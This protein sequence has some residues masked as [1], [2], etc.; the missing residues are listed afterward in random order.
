M[1][2]TISKDN[3][4]SVVYIQGAFSQNSNTD[5]AALCFQNYD[6]DTKIIYNMAEISM[7]DSYGTSCNNGVGELLFKTNNSNNLQER[8]RITHDGKVCIGTDHGSSLLNINGDVQIQDKLVLNETFPTIPSQNNVNFFIDST[9]HLLKLVNNSNIVTTLNPLKIKGDIVVYDGNTETRLPKGI[10][11]QLLMV[12]ETSSVGLAWK[13]VGPIGLQN[14]YYAYVENDVSMSTTST[15]YVD[16]IVFTASNL[17]AGKYRV[18]VSYCV[19]IP[20][21]SNSISVF[22]L[23]YGINM[24]SYIDNSSLTWLT[25]NHV[26]KVNETPLYGSFTVKALT[27]GNHN[28]YLQCKSLNGSPVC[29]NNS[30]I[31]LTFVG[32][33]GSDSFYD[34]FEINSPINTNATDYITVL[35]YSATFLT[36]GQYRIGVSYCISL[37]EDPYSVQLF[38][39]VNSASVRSYYDDQNKVWFSSMHYLNYIEDPVFYNFTVVNLETGDHT[40]YIQLKSMSG[41]DII[42]QNSK[43]EITLVV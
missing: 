39:S 36:S 8:M 35:Q 30:K 37:Q 2:K 41:Q 21:N 31:E 43:L 12:D 33:V 11:N 13:N 34:F 17:Q 18:G 15:D 24:C 23:N 5:I 26:P 38:A 4:P 40:F 3:T 25:A 19:S 22:D 27:E 9:D 42:I 20:E 7:H 16:N 1:F 32:L 28:F 29:V 14:N 10:Q 6:N